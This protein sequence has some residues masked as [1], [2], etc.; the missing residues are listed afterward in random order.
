MATQRARELAA[1]GR[2][3]IALS[4]GEPDFEAPDNVKEAATKAIA[5]GAG[6]Y[7]DVDGT[8]ELKEAVCVKFRRD[9]GLEYRPEQISVGTGAKQVMFNAFT[10]TVASGDEVIIPAPYWVSYPDMVSLAEGVPVVVPCPQEE[11]FKLRPEKLEAAITPRTK[12]V[13]LNSPCNPS[14]AVYGYDELKAL[15]DV[16]LRHPHVWVMTDD[17]YEHL[18]YDNKKF[19][20]AAQ[21][22]P[23]L[24]DRTL[25]V[26]GMSKG[27]A[28]TGWRIGFGAGPRL[29]IRTMAKLQSQV[30]ANP[31]SIS[32]IASIEALLGPQDFMHER[33]A[34]FTRRRDLVVRMLNEAKGLR[35]SV[36]EGAFY[37]YPSCA[38]A[39]GKRTPKGKVI[40]TDHDFSMYLLEDHDVA[41][42]QG[43]AYGLSPFFR[44]SFAIAVDRLEEACERI[45]RACAALQ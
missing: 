1:A 15:T 28:M 22:E 38:G 9:N 5:R 13:V 32:Q 35:C 17:I 39:I 12:W 20:T 41:V 10:A 33:L 45:Q 34:S 36:P 27:Y 7:T 29:L 40:G 19:F 25:T 11:G 2:N 4:N 18:I 23:A 24:Y 21:V 31:C 42:V 16:L 37:V 6:K 43:D 30:T 14:G 3:I 44:I 26:N 8:P